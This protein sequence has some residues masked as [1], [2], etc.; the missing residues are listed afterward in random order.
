[1]TLSGRAGLS[2]GIDIGGTKT[3]ALAVD[4]Q[5]V[6]LASART[7]T[8]TGSIRRFVASAVAAART[9]T[10]ELGLEPAEL[11][12]IGVGVPGQVD[13]VAG[14]VRHAVNLDLGPHPVPLAAHLRDALGTPIHL[15]NDVNAA[16]LGVARMFPEAPDDLAFLSVGT[17]IAAGIVLGGQLRRGFHGVAGEIGHLP[18]D[19]AGERCECGRRG[20]LEVVASGAALA[21]RWPV[22]DGRSAAEELFRAAAGGHPVARSIVED[23]SGHL[24]DAVV[25]LALTVDAGLVVLG[26]GVTEVG[27]PLL[28]SV[29]RALRQRAAAVPL[30]ADLSLD[31]DVVL[32]PDAP[33]GA[34]GAA[35]VARRERA[36]RSRTTV[37]L[38]EAT[39]A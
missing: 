8:A 5:G 37:V 4:E 28:D 3:F 22:E 11:D 18:V 21:R 7:P 29:H 16:T 1:V 26:G 17:G 13:P 31:R 23:V 15:E 30:L 32:A 36:G 25:L 14:T 9:V 34:I 38:H 2:L 35:I 19:P 6:P 24:A 10:G 27:T 39:G 33:V 12:S 20:C